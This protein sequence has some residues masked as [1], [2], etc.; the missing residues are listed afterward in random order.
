MLL[1]TQDLVKCETEP[2][3]SEAAATRRFSAPTSDLNLQ[4]KIL[5]AIP[6]KTKNN[7]K[8]AL[9]VWIAWTLERNLCKETFADGGA[10]IPSDP[11]CLSNELLNYWVAHFIQ[12][13]RRMDSSP[14]PPNSLVQIA[15][16]IQRYDNI[17]KFRCWLFGFRA[18]DEHK[19]LDASQYRIS[20]DTNGN[21]L[22]HN[23]GRLCKNVQG[24]LNN[25]NIDVKRITQKSDPSNPRCLVKIFEKYLS[26]IPR[27]GRFYRKPLPHKASNGSIRFSVQ[28]IGI[29][30][31]SSKMKELFKA[32]QISMTDRN[33]SNHSAKVT[34]CTTLFNASF[35]HF[36]VKSRSGHRSLALD[37]NKRP[38]KALQANDS[39][40]YT[41]AIR[42]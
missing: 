3:V 1:P 33:I 34:C 29:N 36:T 6:K 11:N 30:T 10:S 25:R 9:G 17:L 22:L 26:L 42:Q 37:T 14:Y 23:T 18:L 35:T 7:N 41:A 32:A 5:K 12:E 19:E 27:E 39:K 28:P 40:A 16:G 24:G 31:L 15:S 38:L 8:W 2:V 4:E 20:V 13:C 21:K